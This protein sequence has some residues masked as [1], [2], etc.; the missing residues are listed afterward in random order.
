MVWFVLVHVFTLVLDILALGKQSER[1]K[2]IEILLLRQ[3]LRRKCQISERGWKRGRG[4]DMLK[5]Q[6]EER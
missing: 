4:S 3:Q 1:E 2:D 5:H 6:A